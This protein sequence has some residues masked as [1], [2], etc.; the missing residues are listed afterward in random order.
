MH[1][2]TKLLPIRFDWQKLKQQLK[3]GENLKNSQ[4]QTSIAPPRQ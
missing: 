2:E 1:Y 3:L 4:Y